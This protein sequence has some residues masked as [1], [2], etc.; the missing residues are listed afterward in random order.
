MVR[1]RTGAA[2]LAMV[3]ATGR[4]C[5]TSRAKDGPDSTPHW[6]CGSASRTISC[7]RRAVP[8]SKP[9]QV[10]TMGCLAGPARAAGL[11]A[12]R[13]GR[14]ARPRARPARSGRR[15]RPAAGWRAWRRGRWNIAVPAAGQCRAGS[16]RFPAAPR[17]GCLGGVARPEHGGV[18]AAGGRRQ[19]G[20]PA[21]RA[22]YGDAQAGRGGSGHGAVPGVARVRVTGGSRWGQDDA[23]VAVGAVAVGRALLLGQFGQALLVQGLEVHFGQVQRGI[24]VR[25]IASAMLARRYG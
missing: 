7:G 18:A 2:L 21:S 23:R 6:A 1:S 20:A 25:V 12:R 22:Q 13:R 9:L 14:P 3:S 17:G 10:Q 15:R 8:A 19:G 16:V 24:E 4:P 11:P 5:A